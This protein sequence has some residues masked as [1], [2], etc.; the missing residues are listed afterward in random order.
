[1]HVQHVSNLA[2]E[3]L[4]A[5]DSA[6]A[7][8]AVV[9]APVPVALA[10][11]AELAEAAAGLLLL[12]LGAELLARAAGWAGGGAGRAGVAAGEGAACTVRTCAG[13]GG[14]LGCCDCSATTALPSAVLK[15]QLA[16]DSKPQSLPCWSGVAL[17][18]LRLD[19]HVGAES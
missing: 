8:A 11:A 16:P 19:L 6:T 4:E 3:L 18:L 7:L 14:L 15:M 9:A 10:L 1:M 12:L 13:A 5:T 2:L 17:L